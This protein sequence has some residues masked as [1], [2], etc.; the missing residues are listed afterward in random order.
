[1][2]GRQVGYLQSFASAT[3]IQSASLMP[4]SVADNMLWLPPLICTWLQ[5]IAQNS[6]NLSP[7]SSLFPGPQ[8]QQTFTGNTSAK[9]DKEGNRPA[10]QVG[11]L[12][13]LTLPPV[14]N[15]YSP[16]LIPNSGLEY[17][18]WTF[19]TFHFILRGLNKFWW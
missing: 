9:I 6:S 5:R 14:F 2:P 13:I 15:I 11:K 8:V 12:W 4:C 17:L 1:M 3:Q 19:L 16:N 10:E 18:L 7:H